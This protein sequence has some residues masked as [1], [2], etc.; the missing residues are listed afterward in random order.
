MQNAWDTPSLKNKQ[1]NKC[2]RSSVGHAIR[3][4]AISPHVVFAGRNVW[5]RDGSTKEEKGENKKLNQCCLTEEEVCVTICK[6]MA[7][8]VLLSPRRRLAKLSYLKTRL[9][10]F[11]T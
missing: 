4:M 5:V 7:C 10:D 8:G 9:L 6:I 11:R 3:K 1:A 2:G